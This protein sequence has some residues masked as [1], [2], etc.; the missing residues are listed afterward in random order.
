[1]S[2]RE[3]KVIISGRDAGLKPAL[4]KAARDVEGFR[5]AVEGL[6]KTF[7]TLGIGL[8]VEKLIE[9]GG[10]A[11]EAG[12]HLEHLA[13]QTGL[14][15]ESLS[16]LQHAAT[17]SGV[18]SDQFEAALRKLSTALSLGAV[19][20]SKQADI[21]TSMGIRATDAKGRVLGMDA[22]LGQIADR[23]QKM[24]DGANKSALAIELF[25]RQGAVLVPLLNQGS[26]GLAAL[27][28]EAADLGLT[29]STQTAEAMQQAARSLAVLGES[30]RALVQ[31]FIAGMA[32]A[33]EAV[34][35]ALTVQLGEG[36]DLA[37]TAGEVFGEMLKLLVSLFTNLFTA[38]E[39]AGDKLGLFGLALARL[40]RGDAAGAGG[41]LKELLGITTDNVAQ[42]LEDR[43]KRI[44]DILAGKSALGSV[45]GA[46]GSEDITRP[47]RAASEARLR[48]QIEDEKLAADFSRQMDELRLART[49]EL[50]DKQLLSAEH[51]YD[52]TKKLQ[53][54]QLAAEVYAQQ[55]IVALTRAAA[56][57]EADPARKAKI[58]EELAKAT[59]ALTIATAKL[60]ALQGKTAD[61]ATDAL[62]QQ[63][64]AMARNA[65]LAEDM[66]R[67]IAAV[68]AELEAQVERLNFLEQTGQLSQVERDRLLNEL[69]A[70]AAGQLKEMTI[71]YE[72]LAKAAGD[73]KLVANAA[74]L[75]TK[76]I[77]L[78]HTMNTLRDAGRQ[79]WESGFAT[80][81][82]DIT[83]QSKSAGQAFLDFAK[84]IVSA[85]TQIIAKMIAL[86][87][88]SKL[89][90]LFLGK[91]GGIGTGAAGGG[92]GASTVP[93]T[94]GEGVPGLASGGSL[95]SGQLSLVGERGPE[96]FVPDSGGRV[97]SNDAMRKLGSGG[98]ATYYID[99][100]GSDASV[101]QHVIRAIEARDKINEKRYVAM[102]LDRE[103]RG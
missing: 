53:E 71:D 55:Q 90:G 24:P 27:K 16:A 62:K 100:R 44:D 36:F 83:T 37:R 59:E 69:R 52:Q 79:A 72:R 14:S 11:L 82:S 12:A 15:A 21:W 38:I 41:A 99:A 49:K 17:V 26:Q 57:K 73:P 5:G 8:I 65:F 34:G 23:F 32:P 63:A 61:G 102:S 77:E 10:Q 28:K 68:Y 93:F 92:V 74:A 101:Y 18:A 95:G 3:V 33:L 97:I 70:K 30:A 60:N 56:A 84:T 39:L 25:G 98:G 46:P 13:Q 58:L 85:L 2:E 94:G 76:L 19:S 22:A 31:Q 20:G 66:G 86:W 51:Y 87:L 35:Q 64:D 9:L 88:W 54:D 67:R 29:M 48:R 47:D 6:Q 50:Y 89:T 91:A 96:L 81:F 4:D 7:E 42:L 75:N 80:F 43:Q 103:R 45:K 78:A 40:A 1:M